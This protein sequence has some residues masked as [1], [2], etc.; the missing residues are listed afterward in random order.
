MKQR[1]DLHLNYM[2]ILQ[3][4]MK[5]CVSL[6]LDVMREAEESI[7]FQK[8]LK[9]AQARIDFLQKELKNTKK[10]NESLIKE[11]KEA[12]RKIAQLESEKERIM[13][14][15]SDFETS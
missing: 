1:L 12:E 15:S 14:E 10:A 3:A 6:K 9:S 11:K 8:K 13:V 2:D 5:M 7:K 4:S